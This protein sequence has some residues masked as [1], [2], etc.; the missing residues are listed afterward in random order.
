ML[1]TA[2]PQPPAEVSPAAWS[3]S[4]TS[5][6]APSSSQ[7]SWT[8]WR[9]D[10]SPSPRPNSFEISPIARSPRGETRPPGSLIRSMN[11]PT[12]GLSWYRPHHLS[13]TMSSSGT[14]S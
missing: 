13:R 1:R 3:R 4:N 6:S 14:R 8:F 10:S 5:G 9:V 11:V 2:S 7:W 12:F